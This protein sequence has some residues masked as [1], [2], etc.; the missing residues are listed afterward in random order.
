MPYGLD[1]H[2]AYGIFM[3]MSHGQ[4]RRPQPCPANVTKKDPFERCVACRTAAAM[5]C[6]PWRT[7]DCLRPLAY[8]WPVPYAWLLY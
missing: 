4:Y 2:V 7:A 5:A 1:V 8:P 3:P 6:D